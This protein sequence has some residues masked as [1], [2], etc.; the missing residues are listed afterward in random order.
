MLLFRKYLEKQ[1]CLCDGTLL[2]GLEAIPF[3]QIL[4]KLTLLSMVFLRM[5]L[6]LWSLA[7][8]FHHYCSKPPI[9]EIPK[10]KFPRQS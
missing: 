1:V 7:K 8:F 3:D 2:V 5:K 9:F 6:D 10:I 4:I